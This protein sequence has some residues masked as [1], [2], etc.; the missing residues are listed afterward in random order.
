MSRQVR[1]KPSFMCLC[2]KFQSRVLS[3]IYICIMS[4]IVTYEKYL[5]LLLGISKH[6]LYLMR[7]NYIHRLCKGDIILYKLSHKPLKSITKKVV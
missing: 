2:G 7:E 6:I 4:V 3:G 5:F 1:E